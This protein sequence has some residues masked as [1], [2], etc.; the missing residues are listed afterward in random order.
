[1]L[2]YNQSH[3]LQKQLKKQTRKNFKFLK[4]QLQLNNFDFKSDHLKKISDKKI[5]GKKE[6]KFLNEFIPH[7]GL[8]PRKEGRP[9]VRK[10]NANHS[11]TLKN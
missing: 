8:H 6:A 2:Q 1:M 10:H 11:F 5:K 4:P 7:V 3:K 9:N